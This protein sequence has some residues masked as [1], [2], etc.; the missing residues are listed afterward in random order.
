VSDITNLGTLSNNT[1]G[2]S[3]NVTG[4]VTVAHGGTG[5]TTYNTAGVLYGNT[6]N[7]ITTIPVS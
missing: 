6:N 3:A 5:I 1:T 7:T 4:T 2:N